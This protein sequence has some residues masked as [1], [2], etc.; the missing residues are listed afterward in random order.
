MKKLFNAIFLWNAIKNASLDWFGSQVH[1][2]RAIPRQNAKHI[3]AVDKLT[4]RKTGS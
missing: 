4:A 3:R 1:H 2:V